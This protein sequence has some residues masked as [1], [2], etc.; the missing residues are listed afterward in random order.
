MQA[1]EDVSSKENREKVVT[2]CLVESSVAETDKSYHK[3]KEVE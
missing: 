2:E 1:Y 3:V